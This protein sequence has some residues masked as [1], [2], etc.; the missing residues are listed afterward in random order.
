MNM[1][2][3]VKSGLE[4]LMKRAVRNL[5]KA[6]YTQ[7]ADEYANAMIYINENFG[8][9]QTS[10]KI[11][12]NLIIM[13]AVLEAL[14]QRFPAGWMTQFSSAKELIAWLYAQEER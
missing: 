9:D 10:P 2:A 11:L 6:S 12:E 8:K 14:N 1:R 7:L 3:G 5:K 4:V 13:S